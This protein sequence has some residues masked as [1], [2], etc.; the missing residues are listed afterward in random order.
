LFLSVGANV[1]YMKWSCQKILQQVKIFSRKVIVGMLRLLLLVV[2]LPLLVVNRQVSSSDGRLQQW[3]SSVPILSDQQIQAP[4]NVDISERIGMSVSWRISK[5]RGYE[6]R[7]SYWHSY[8]PTILYL[9]SLL[10]LANKL[11]MEYW[12]R[13]QAGSLGLSTSGPTPSPPHFS[14]SACLS[15]SGFHYSSI[16][17]WKQRRVTQ[18]NTNIVFQDGK[19]EIKTKIKSSTTNAKVEHATEE[20]IEDLEASVV[21]VAR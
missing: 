11:P 3:L 13:R 2:S 9:H 16:Q 1:D 10:K 7:V 15:L 20:E 5:Q 14:C 8:L 12:L 18:D 21:K 6:F 4:L 17:K 19:K